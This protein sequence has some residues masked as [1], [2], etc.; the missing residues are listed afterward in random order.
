[1]KRVELVV[2][3]DHRLCQE[4]GAGSILQRIL[5]GEYVDVSM[6]CRV[7]YDVCSICGNKA[8]T[9]G[10]Y[11]EHIRNR[12]VNRDPTGTGLRPYMVNVE[13][14]FFDLSFVYVGADRAARV[15]KK[16]AGMEKMA[17]YQLLRA[18][19]EKLAAMGKFSGVKLADLIKYMVP[20]LE[21]G[22]AQVDEE[23]LPPD[24][25]EEL[26]GVGLP[27]ALSGVSRMR[28]VLQPREFAYLA[29]RSAGAPPAM[30]QALPETLPP[31]DEVSLPVGMGMEER[32][33]PLVFER[34]S[35]FF[36]GRAVIGPIVRRRI[37]IV[38]RRP[39]TPTEKISSVL[40]GELLHKLAS[41]YNGYRLWLLANAERF[42][43][44][45][46]TA[47]TS[48]DEQEAVLWYLENANWPRL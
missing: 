35:P 8:R 45:T 18:E 13:P 17:S 29:L 39:P 31:S 21:P 12:R 19:L 34:L 9:R 46:K 30:C 4:R 38:M 22:E 24:V 37:I 32:V 23:G 5:D 28:M 33:P 48:E 27:A 25:L 26:S 47:A 11:C 43:F 20:P 14:R 3:L 44:L 40:G 10:E 7:P 1:M 36:S 42:G 16:L 41:A 2:R 15:L 6:G